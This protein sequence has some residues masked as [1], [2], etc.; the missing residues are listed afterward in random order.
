MRRNTPF[1]NTG[2]LAAIQ[3]S[4][5]VL[6][7]AIPLIS[8]LETSGLALL[9]HKARVD[10]SNQYRK[11][12]ARCKAE[13]FIRCCKVLFVMGVQGCS[14]GGSPLALCPLPA[15]AGMALP[16]AFSETLFM[17]TSLLLPQSGCET[18]SFLHLP[19]SSL[20][21]GFYCWGASHPSVCMLNT[22]NVCVL[23]SPCS[24]FIL[25]SVLHVS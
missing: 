4:G 15:V 9:P 2:L 12:H 16:A 25:I 7:P 18:L 6:K 8:V 22:P 10:V 24:L 3:C 19:N 1:W 13:L 23:C 11:L 21:R 5:G 20:H 14:L 17:Q